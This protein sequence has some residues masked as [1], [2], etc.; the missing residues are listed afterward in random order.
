MKI[1]VLKKP[2]YYKGAINHFLD[3]N[4]MSHGYTYPDNTGM[5]KPEFRKQQIIQAVSICLW[6]RRKILM[7]R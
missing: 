5:K 1:T 4:Q 3:L 6:M 2:S 7:A